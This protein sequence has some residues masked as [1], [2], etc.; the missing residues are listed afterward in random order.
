MAQF[1]RDL[2]TACIRI[3]SSEIVDKHTEYL[4]EVTVG[5]YTWT[6]K[7]RYSDFYELHEK[8]VSQCKIDKTLLPPK[9]L[10]GNQ[11]ETFIK[12][13]QTELE[14]YLQTVLFYMT[15]KIA[16][17]LAAFLEF[18]N[19]EI[20]G[21]TQ[22]MAEDLY[23]KGDVLLQLKEV[24]SVTPLQLHCLTERLKLPEPTCDSG[25]TKKD[26]GHI[27]DFITRVKC[28]HVKGQQHKV[29][30][31]NIL[32][33]K[34]KFDLTL[35]KSLECLEL[36]HCDPFLISGLETNKQSIEHLFIHYSLNSIR[37]IMLQDIPHWKAEDGTMVV[38]HWENLIEVDFS[39][40]SILHIDDSVQLLPRVEVLDLSYNKLES[41][42]HLNW[43][44]QLTILN[45]SYNNISH[46]DSLHT[47]LGNLKKLNLAGNK[48]SSLS[49][50][51]KL[52]SLENLDVMDNNISQIPEVKYVCGL[53]CLECLYLTGNPVTAVLDYRTKVLAMF[54]DRVVEATLDQEKPTEKELDT[55]RVVQAIQKSK[56]KKE[57]REKEKTTSYTSLRRESECSQTSELGW[58]TVRPTSLSSASNQESSN[59]K[60]SDIGQNR[61]SSTSS[62]ASL[63]SSSELK[64]DHLEEQTMIGHKM[65]GKMVK[66]SKDS[67]AINCSKLPT[68]HNTDFATWMQNRLFGTLTDSEPVAEKIIDILWCMVVQYSN[69]QVIEPSC[70]VLTERR[71]FILRLKK[72]KSTS[73]NIPEMETFY[74]M[75]LSNIHEVLIGACYSFIRLEESFV[76]SSGTF[77]L[78]V[79]DADAGK[80]FADGVENC[81]KQD[82]AVAGI[83]PFTN[84]SQYGD[85]AKHIFKLEDEQGLST[86]RLAF[87]MCVTIAGIEQMAM[88][89]LSENGVYLIDLDCLFWPKPS[90][91][92]ILEDIKSPNFT[93]LQNHSIGTK[94]SDITINITFKEKH[95][96]LPHQNHIKYEKYGFS[97]IFHELIGPV[98][99]HVSFFSVKSRDAFLDRLTNLRSEHA[100]QM[101]PTIREEPEGGNE[102]SDSQDISSEDDGDISIRVSPACSN[103]TSKDR[104]FT[105]A[106]T[107]VH[108]EQLGLSGL[109]NKMFDVPYLTPE[110][111][112]HLQES[113]QSYS[114]IKPL[115]SKLEML[116]KASGN[117]LVHYFHS[118]ISL[119][120]SEQ[121]Q[122]H[123]VMWGTVVPYQD[124]KH[125][126]VTLIMFSTRSMY[127]ISEQLVKSPV[128][129]RPSWMTHSRNKSDSVIGFQVKH[130]DKH[131]S[132]GIIHSSQSRGT[133]IRSYHVF[134]YRDLKQ[135]NIGLFDQCVRITGKDQ[136]SV[137]TIVTRDSMV[138]EKVLHYLNA[139]L[140]IFQSSPMLE[141]SSSDLEQDFYRAFDK[142][143][144]TTIE[145]MEYTHPSRVQFVYPGEDV[146]TD[147]L[148]V[149]TEH[150]RLPLN[151]KRKADILMYLQG[152]IKSS[153]S[154]G[155]ELLSK[156]IVLTN[157]Y[158][159]IINEDVVSYPLPDFVRGIPNTPRYVLTECRKVDFL[160]RILLFKEDS[161]IAT[162]IFSDEPDDIVVDADHF[163]LDSDSKGR[164]SPP[165]I[166]IMLFIQSVK[167]MDKF[168]LLLKNQ[169][170]DIQHGSELE[171]HL[172]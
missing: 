80:S 133:I 117:D 99:F 74:I 73:M 108:S 159:C 113:L 124:I 112:S 171:V 44:S 147:L 78:V 157:Q 141:K 93:F 162:L 114:L 101:S 32:M 1:G 158:L 85:L 81:L 23:N 35:Y 66:S 7:H 109:S 126:I 54:G 111:G 115:T 92:T 14:I 36:E 169:W 77:A 123:H 135:V 16:P 71:I 2:D 120:G 56:E 122:L 17:P 121:E 25:D 102:S 131:H 4:I 12:K 134:N 42:E 119:I 152:Y 95:K 51:S 148:Y 110:L 75:P 125:E 82:Q 170:R 151:A 144:K 165:E 156:S 90:Y 155:I 79:T 168:V 160:K 70:V 97:M 28:L 20:H 49:G 127:F 103:M 52:F 21:I 138:T 63:T 105:V 91:I 153:E 136:N 128:V 34:L 137:Y 10:F 145:G 60:S 100:H 19:Y 94:I 50:L 11:N 62:M 9:K 64:Q 39:H 98:G 61:T 8:L 30:S 139:M 149:I 41:I 47:K 143:T 142:R 69:Q 154:S 88:L 130:L 29:G 116:A 13:R 33:S 26:I 15:H 31:S 67:S 48:L 146:I 18:H 132:S 58:S 118:D 167:E 172:L 161:K 83:S 89:L 53:P 24:Y 129:E 68:M 6:V 150:L 40:N 22:T 43:L 5:T 65:T 46:L 84:H 27:L 55:V 140:S 72:G 107:N 76:S 3:I 104:S 166:E 38:S 96:T 163:S 86:G 57:E 45:L 87:A 59:I 164:Q 37:D 106:G